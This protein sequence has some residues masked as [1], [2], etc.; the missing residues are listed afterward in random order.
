MKLT[1]LA[2]ELKKARE[3]N[4]ELTQDQENLADCAGTEGFGYALFEGGYIRPD[5]WVEGEDLVKLNE[6][7]KIVWEFKNL[8]ENLA[9]EM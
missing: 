2:E 5:D 4:L 6:A 1:K 3:N 7:I 8:F 9:T